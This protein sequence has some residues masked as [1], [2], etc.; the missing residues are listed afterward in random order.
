MVSSNRDTDEGALGDRRRQ[1]EPSLYETLGALP[2]VGP[3]RDFEAR[4]FARVS[5]RRDSGA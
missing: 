2:R 1:L 3:W 5:Q 4:L